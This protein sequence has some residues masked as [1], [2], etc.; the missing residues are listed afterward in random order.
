MKKVWILLF[1]V[2]FL[3]VGTSP[4]LSQEEKK[5]TDTAVG[6]ETQEEVHPPYDPR[7]RRDPFRNLLAGRD[8]KEKA[9][10]G[11]VPQMSIDDVNLIGIVEAKGIYTAIIN[12]PQGFPYFIKV[13][14]K[15]ADGFVLSIKEFQVVFRK[16]EERGIPFPKPKDIVKEIK[17]EER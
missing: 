13:G 3:A 9:L 8:I 14:Q 15:F 16:T 5:S 12:G 1:L 10:V 4:L 17:P 11:G 6:P 7:G 2:S